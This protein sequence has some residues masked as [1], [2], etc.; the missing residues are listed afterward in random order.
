MSPAA[1]RLLLVGAGQAHLGVL[2]AFARQP[3]P[4]GSE[5]LLVNPS[6]TAVLA[7]LVPGVVAGRFD[8]ALARRHLVSMAAAAG[9]RF[10]EG[11]VVALDARSRRLTLADGSALDYELLSLGIGSGVDRDA[12]AGAREH[13]LALRPLEP[14]MALQPAL[15]SLAAQ[16]SVNLL[17]IGDGADAVELALALAARAARPAAGRSGSG[18]P[19]PGSDPA[20]IA[21]ACGAG[22]L[23][24]GWPT[25]MVQRARAVLARRRVTVFPEAVVAL[26]GRQ[27]R[28]ASGARLAC[29]GAVLATGPQPWPWLA[30]S[31]L[32]LAA[33]GFVATQATLQSASHP[34]VFAAGTCALRVDGPGRPPEEGPGPARGRQA[35][36]ALAANLRRAL[37]GAPPRPWAGP[38]PGPFELCTGDGGALVRFAG[39]VFEGRLPGWWKERAERTR[40]ARW[41]MGAEPAGAAVRQPAGGAAAMVAKAGAEGP[42]GPQATAAISGLNRP[43]GN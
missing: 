17:V 15:A 32:A 35:G 20:R 19:G 14:F 34:E 36:A 26:D 3:P 18:A 42:A 1:R 33:G 22:G 11:R 31:G 12:V 2:D 6:P 40:L 41:A 8:A 30:G 39:G 16:G 25:A 5:V 29:D 10:V 37:A 9:V 21:L 7:G 24:P 4:A 43:A 23:L 27:A 28:L 38:R 13:A